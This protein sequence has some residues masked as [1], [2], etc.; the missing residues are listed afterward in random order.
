MA[1]FPKYIK[2]YNTATDSEFIQFDN[3]TGE[4]VKDGLAFETTITDDDA[5]IPSSGAIV[6]YSA[7][8]TPSLNP[9]TDTTYTLVITDQDKLVTLSNESAITMTVPPNSSVAFPTGTTI[10]FAQL[11][12]GQVTFAQGLGVTIN[13]YNADLKLTGQYSMA[14]LVKRDTD[15][16]LLSGDITT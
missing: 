8:K 3:T 9:Q 16:W 2:R 12:A 14:T 15:I 6:D 10:F 11:G 13:S 5:K 4:K 7:K 1:I